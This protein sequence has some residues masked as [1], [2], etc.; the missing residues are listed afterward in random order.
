MKKQTKR[1]IW[2]LVDPIKHAIDGARTTDQVLTNKLLV[3]E[4]SALDSMVAGQGTLHDW[5]TLTDVLNLCET[6]AVG[7]VGPEALPYCETAQD[8]LQAAA[9]R[10]Q[11]IGKMGLTA[12]GIEAMRHM[13][14]Y[15]DLQRKSISRAEYNNWIVKTRNM[16]RSKSRRVLEIS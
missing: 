3:M 10:Y 2:P 13:I 15:H 8:D 11:R 6:M 16:I 14:E 4:L 1:K 9:F 12:T 5:H 7:G